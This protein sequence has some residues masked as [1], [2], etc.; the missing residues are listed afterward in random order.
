MRGGRLVLAGVTFT[1]SPGESMLLRGPNGAGKSSLL[2]LLAGFLAPS[3]G[4]LSW[5]AGRRSR[6]GPSTAPGCT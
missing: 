2:R 1:L 6:T 5:G 4:A 3:A